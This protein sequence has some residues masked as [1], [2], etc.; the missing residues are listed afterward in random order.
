MLINCAAYED[1]IKIADIPT[2]EISD[3]LERPQAFV[4]V[5]LRDAN[6][7]ELRVMQ[8]EFGMIRRFTHTQEIELPLAVARIVEDA[9]SQ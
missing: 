9:L 5:A 8:E 6:D 4:W 7:A 1:G 2:E 3:F